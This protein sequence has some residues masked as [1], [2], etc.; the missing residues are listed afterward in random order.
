MV[1]ILI[2]YNDSNRSKLDYHLMPLGFEIR[3]FQNP[4][5]VIV[6]LDKIDFDVVLFNAV[7]YP[8]HWKPLLSLIRGEKTKQDV[9]F[10]LF[11]NRDFS[12]EEACKANYLGAN[13]LILD[14]LVEIKAFFKIIETLRHYKGITD[15][16]KFTRYIVDDDDK[17]ALMFMHPVSTLLIYGKVIDISIEGLRFKPYNPALSQDIPKGALITSCSLRAGDNIVTTN[18]V[19]RASSDMMSMKFEFQD[20]KEHQIFFSYLIKTPTRKIR[21]R[22]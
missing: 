9:V 12:I 15:K 3:Y 8:R 11:G 22:I 7:D 16:R 19:V 13:S 20:N 6:N 2:A 21:R 10:I 5:E 1:I 14:D 17:I 4:L 18:L